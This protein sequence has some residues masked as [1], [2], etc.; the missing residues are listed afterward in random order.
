MNNANHKPNESL[1]INLLIFIILFILICILLWEF[2]VFIPIQKKYNSCQNKIE[3]LQSDLYNEQRKIRI[4][5]R[6]IK[7]KNNDNK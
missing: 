1:A 3:T 7:E 6:I 4:L 2:F 5:R